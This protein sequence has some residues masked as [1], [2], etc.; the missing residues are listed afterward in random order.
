MKSKRTISYIGLW[1]L[2]LPWL[3]FS[4]KTTIVLFSLTG[5]V[6]LVIGNRQ[7]HNEKKKQK[8]NKDDSSREYHSTNNSI[9]VLD[10][11]TETFNTKQINP[12]DAGIVSYSDN[13]GL[14]SNIVKTQSLNS[15]ND[16]P[17]PAIKPRTRK[18]VEMAPRV[19]RLTIKKEPN[20]INNNENIDP[21]ELSD[22]S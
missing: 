2:V 12:N 1:A 13:S 14:D 4:W 11:N 10:N 18:R 7:Y 15:F 19:K 21:N 3:G 6:L 16:N 17:A 8:I 5:V 22:F 20:F 9:D